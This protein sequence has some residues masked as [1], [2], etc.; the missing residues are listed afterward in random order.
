MSL[1]NNTPLSRRNVL[2]AITVTTAG[3]AAARMTTGGFAWAGP[4]KANPSPSD[5]HKL[6]QTGVDELH[7]LGITGVQGLCR[8]GD[9]DVWALAGTR[10]VTTHEPV[11]RNSHFRIGSNTKTFT[12]V[13][14]LRLVEEGGLSLEDTVESRLPGVVTGKHYDGDTITIRQLLQHTSGIRDCYELLPI[15]RDW[16]QNFE[17]HR[18]DH[19]DPLDV[20]KLTMTQPPSFA[21]GTS[22]EYSNT[23][24]TLVGL[25]IEAVTKHPLAAEFTSRIL[26]PL[27]M[28]HTVSPGDSPRLPDPHSRAY[29][30]LTENGPL[31]DVTEYNVSADVAN[32]SLIST[33]EDVARFWQALMRGQLLRPAQLKEMLQTILMAAGDAL[34]G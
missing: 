12:S 7:A 18:Y 4:R 6:L 28:H 32:G 30:R 3:V 19:C 21:P 9:Q 20:V 10:D 16:P 5:P 14:A 13:V 17:A 26:R 33:P 29:Q 23:G 31:L 27:R 15:F 24:Y 8:S 25:I 34:T 11:I 2:A 22:W 1:A